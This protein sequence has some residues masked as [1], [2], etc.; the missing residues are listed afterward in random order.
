MESDVPVDGRGLID[1]T[2]AAEQA[3]AKRRCM[4][5]VPPQVLE[6]YR[7]IGD[8]ASLLSTEHPRGEAVEAE[9]EISDAALETV[10]VEVAEPAVDPESGYVYAEGE[11]RKITWSDKSDYVDWTPKSETGKKATS[12][13][14]FDS[15][16]TE[17]TKEFYPDLSRV[18]T[19]GNAI[20]YSL[21]EEPEPDI[22]SVTRDI[23]R[24]G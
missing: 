1:P 3:V 16:V 15:L 22:L 7:A 17:W 8:G 11:P 24:G 12:E 13:D 4:G 9:A 5:Y 21:L 20:D 2:K 10:W 6:I 19:H 14:D 23:A 18:L